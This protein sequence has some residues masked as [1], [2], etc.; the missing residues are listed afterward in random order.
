M[1]QQESG[2]S[3]S[4]AHGQSPAD[5][6]PDERVAFMTIVRA[7]RLA[8]ARLAENLRRRDSSLTLLSV[9][10]S[11]VAAVL[12]AGPAVGGPDLTRALGSAGPDT[13]SWRILCGVAS[14]CSLLAAVATNWHRQG[15]VASRLAR[16][17]A[18]AARLEALELQVAFQ[19]TPLADA[20]A[21][22][23]RIIGELPP[24]TE[25]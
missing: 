7:R 9:I 15:D 11:A 17:Q 12:T 19:G 20:T 24:V 10:A 3:E 1:R 14:I 4:G 23:G 13:P 21:E 16:C 25:R 8:V 18:G 2:N 22:Y 6:V 5:P